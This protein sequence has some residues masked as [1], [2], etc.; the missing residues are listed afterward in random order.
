MLTTW[1]PPLAWISRPV[2][3][4]PF[5]LLSALPLRGDT[6]FTLS[7]LATLASS[8]VVSVTNKAPI[9]RSPRACFF[10]SFVIEVCSAYTVATAWP[11]ERV[12]VW[13]RAGS[14]GGAGRLPCAACHA[15]G[16]FTSASTCAPRGRR[17][18]VPPRCPLP[19]T[20]LFSVSVSLGGFVSVFQSPCISGVSCCLSFSVWP[21]SLSRAPRGPSALCQRTRLLFPSW[22][23]GAPS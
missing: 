11:A 18:L 14:G 3:V 21:A 17:P 6:S 22:P 20:G 12:R 23:S 13:R 15:R 19:A 2:L 5:L 10:L 4:F 9:G 8:E 16:W 1:L 7:L